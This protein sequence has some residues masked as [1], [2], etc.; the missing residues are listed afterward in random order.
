MQ[1][2]DINTTL[3]QQSFKKI[4]GYCPT[5]IEEL[6]GG[7][8]SAVYAVNDS[9]SGLFAVKIYPDD[10]NGNNTR[11]E[12]EFNSFKFLWDNNVRSVPEPIAAAPEAQL[13]IYSYIELNSLS[14]QNITSSDV[15][16]ATDFLMTL[17][18]LCE[19][20]ESL[21]IRDAKDACFSLQ[22]GIN[23]VE[24]RYL[25]LEQISET[26]PDTLDLV[27][28]LKSDFLPTFANIKEWCQHTARDIGMAYSD[29]IPQ[30]YRTLS[31]S[32][33]GFHNT[34]RNKNGNLTFLD[35]EYFGWDDPV[36]LISDF[37]VHPGMDLDIVL[38]Q[39]FIER[40]FIGFKNDTGLKNRLKVM[41]PIF[42]IKWCLILLNEFNP[43]NFSKRQ[44]T[45]SAP[46]NLK[47]IQ[48][49]QL[50]KSKRMLDMVRHSYEHFP[51]KI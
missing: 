47:E 20:P 48:S 30:R 36:K 15:D 9:D 8:N 19:I 51:Y 21:D 31:P 18:K 42:G 41:F 25:E 50:I 28:Y 17:N 5:H 1:D 39:Q 38:K 14:S 33:F 27:N 23:A 4:F 40:M 35:F 49:Q 10:C 7:R 37:L 3:I 12:S 46:A 45:R 24:S 13:A 6:S 22:M 2:K 34:V 26:I 29:K 16:E 44:L 11:L 43:A 32:D